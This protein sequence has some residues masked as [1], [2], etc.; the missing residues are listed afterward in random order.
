MNLNAVRG[1]VA[2]AVRR[3]GFR[4][5]LGTFAIVLVAIGAGGSAAAGWQV[6]S[7]LLEK[8]TTERLD[9]ATVTF[10]SMYQQRVAEAEL[11]ARQ[12]SER[13]AVADAVRARDPIPI[14]A[15]VEPILVLRPYYRF[16]VAS[17][18]GTVVARAPVTWQGTGEPPFA[19]PGTAEAFE[20][21]S[22]S[23]SLFQGRG[24]DLA[25][26]V[27]APTHDTSGSIVGIVQVR[28][29]MDE[30]FVRRVKAD[31]GLD[32]SL[33]C[34][35][36]ITATTLPGG[37]G[38][39]GARA[40]EAVRA[41]VLGRAESHEA[42][43]A[44]PGGRRYRLRWT[45]LADIEGQ[46]VAMYAVGNPAQSL[47]DAQ[48]GILST[49]VPITGGIATLAMVL[50]S[51]GSF[52][53]TG[54]LRR[55]ARD[56]ARIG[57][58]D[59]D[60]PV[61]VAPSRDEVGQL[62]ARMEEMRRS[63]AS[64][65]LRLRGLND[66]KDEYLFSVA[67]E[68]R[69][70]MASLVALV[71]VLGEDVDRLSP[72]ELRSV[73]A[74]ISRAA[75]RLNTL[76]ENV[77]DAGSIRAGRFTI[78]MGR[79]DLSEVIEVAV[80]TIAPILEEKGQRVRVAG[81]DGELAPYGVVPPLPVAWGD[82]RR[83][84]QVMANLVGNASKY[85]PSGDEIVVRC[86]EESLGPGTRVMARVSVTDN[87]PGIPLPEQAD[88]F[89]RHFRASSAV[90]AAPGTGLGLAITRAIIEAHGGSVGLDSEPGRGTTVW[91]TV[92][93]A[94]EEIPQPIQ[95]LVSNDA[96]VYGSSHEDSGHR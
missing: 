67:H 60:H 13:R 39:P 73:V 50:A 65:Y 36:R 1:H 31:T 58:G 51:L 69:T 77:L 90:L 18:D 19:A 87:G 37:T 53:L 43:L 14:L 42:A 38:A 41:A 46:P 15:V 68:V 70:P 81:L 49:Y 52:V 55:L 59:L 86:T 26:V 8:A 54:P 72:D 74:K 3:L 20:R 48:A 76:V 28:F 16:V 88:V 32:S 57:A 22:T 24:C 45:P 92:G 17:E 75:I 85:G 78:R 83:L 84:G 2:R 23:T 95:T 7:S 4:T 47:L 5:Q 44:L 27:S 89:E 94:N 6:V 91:F 9:L 33:Y 93:L 79:V 34:G 30:E 11:V 21:D 25:V 66:L 80:G 62:A 64:T 10:A 61:T 35:D 71:E 12:V 63:I 96:N 56:A 82:V 40:P 29:P